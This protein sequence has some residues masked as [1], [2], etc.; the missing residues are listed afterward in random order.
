MTIKTF[1]PNRIGGG[2]FQLEQDATGAYAIKEVGF[3]KLPDLKL[4]EINQ[5]AY[6]APPT[7]DDKTTTPDPCPPGFKL[8]DGVCQRI[9]TSGNQGDGGGRNNFDYT[10]GTQYRDI[11]KEATEFASK[12]MGL[13]RVDKSDI[14]QGAIRVED[15]RSLESM[16]KAYQNVVNEYNRHQSD[17]QQRNMTGSVDE[18][19]ALEDL[20]YSREL[21]T[22]INEMKG[23]S[24]TTKEG[25]ASTAGRADTFT[26][27]AAPIGD[28]SKGPKTVPQGTL[29]GAKTST[30]YGVPDAIKFGQPALPD[31]S[32]MSKAK[33][34]ATDAVK[35]NK[36]IKLVGAGIRMAAEIGSGI[37]DA[38]LGVTPAEKIRREADTAAAKSLGYTTNYE[39][40]GTTDPGRIASVRLR[41]GTIATSAADSVLVGFN[42]DSAKGDLSGAIAGRISTRMN[43]GQARVDAKYG[44]D[45]KKSKEFAAKTRSFQKEAND[46]NSAKEAAKTKE[47]KSTNPNMRSG[48]DN[49][50]G[51]GCF[52][53]G[54]LITMFDGSKKPV[55]QVNL[56]DNV[57]IGGNVFAVGKFLN[58]ELY[59]Y[60][61]I[62]VSGSHMVNEDGTWIRVRDTKHG[63]SLGDDLNTVYVFG[64]ENRRI[65]I[66][67][68]LFTDYFEVSEQ[69]QLV[70]NEED[71]FN[72]WKSYG[73]TIN[74]HNVNTLN[75]N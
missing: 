22:Q 51:G 50:G 20:M 9:E 7:E 55:E 42:R 58:T 47:T 29:T 49:G 28:F 33:E 10:G 69:D 53:K 56:G 37:G 34:F 12:D 54:T 48:A 4:P 63:K 30:L 61:G 62:K 25:F 43:V 59:N 73:N 32:L 23:T 70:N 52:I 67:D 57:A 26:M 36:S 5:A 46:F 14:N 45:S 31:K 39:L 41:D 64:S 75:A 24:V 18:E 15:I 68:I 40:G 19:Q 38:I 1:D 72:N 16:P 74:E 44:K 27:D 6:T 21:R 35:N 3:V 11:Q 17:V 60:K 71:F 8:V 66:D 65:L 13:N 2:T